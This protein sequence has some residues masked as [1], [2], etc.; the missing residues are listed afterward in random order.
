M[1]IRSFKDAVYVNKIR[2]LPNM[3]VQCNANMVTG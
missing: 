1:G 2:K 3:Q